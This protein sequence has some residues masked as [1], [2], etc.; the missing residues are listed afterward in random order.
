MKLYEIRD[1]Q[2]RVIAFEVDN[3]LIS[4]RRVARIVETIVGA[5]I[6]FRPKWFF[7]PQAVFCKFEIEGDRFCV[8]EPFGDNSRYW[9]GGDPPGWYQTFS[10]VVT[11]FNLA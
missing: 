8:E 3:F 7:W 5:R 2:A 6:T 4:R 1:E 9:I 10:Q 11:A